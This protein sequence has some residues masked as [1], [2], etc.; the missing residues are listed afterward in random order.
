MYAKHAIAV[1]TATAVTLGL[2]FLMQYL[3]ATGEAAIVERKPRAVLKFIYE[4]TDKP[5]PSVEDELPD[6]PPPVQP[7]PSSQVVL[8]FD[9]DRSATVVSFGAP[10][11]DKPVNPTAPSFGVSDGGVLPITKVAPV[12]PAR[13]RTL[14]LEGHVIVEFTVTHL[15]NVTDIVVVESTSRIF[16]KAAVAAAARFRYRPR[17]IDGE[18]IDTPGVQNKIT[19]K[20][21]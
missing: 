6:R 11:L 21:E 10:E 14:G 7:P 1:F 12:Y 13:A 2:L 20:L 15:G 5:A 18:A 3:I 4:K 9:G 16:E 19:F 8:P 17:V